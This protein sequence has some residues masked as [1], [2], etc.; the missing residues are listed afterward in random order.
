MRAHNSCSLAMLQRHLK[1]DWNAATELSN[2]LLKNGIITAKANAYGIHAAT[3]PLS[4]S[5]FLQPLDTAKQSISTAKKAIKAESKHQVRQSE[6]ESEIKQ[7]ESFPESDLEQ[8][9][10]VCEDN[11]EPSGKLHQSE[12]VVCNPKRDTETLKPGK[13]REEY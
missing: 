2:L 9:E 1:L 5:A 3:S 8:V 13:Q 6:K 11:H 12:D 4:K 10:S 7:M